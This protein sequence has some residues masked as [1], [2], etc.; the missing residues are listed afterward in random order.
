[1]GKA[2]AFHLPVLNDSQFKV[3]KLVLE[4]GQ[5]R[6]SEKEADTFRL[7]IPGTQLLNPYKAPCPTVLSRED[8]SFHYIDA[9]VDRQSFRRKTPMM[10]GI[11]TAAYY[12]LIGFGWVLRNAAHG[13]ALPRENSS[14]PFSRLR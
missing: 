8:N 12:S 3:Y 2:R 5:Y 7:G 10:I 13:P 9:A 11:S 4:P 14:E 1:M 6:L